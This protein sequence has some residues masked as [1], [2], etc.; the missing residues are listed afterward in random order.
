MRELL[1]V[2]VLGCYEYDIEMMRQQEVEGYERENFLPH[3]VGGYTIREG[4]WDTFN[5]SATSW[6]N[7]PIFFI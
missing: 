6:N 1:N 4:A 7:D 2:V 3:A 5:S